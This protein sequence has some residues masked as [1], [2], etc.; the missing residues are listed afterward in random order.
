[1]T[2]AIEVITSVQRR[3]RW[4]KPEKE[5]ICCGG[6]GAGR[7]RVRNSSRGWDPHEPIVPVAPQLCERAQESVVFNPVAIVT[8]NGTFVANAAATPEPGFIEIEFA[9]S[10]RIRITGLVD[11]RSRAARGSGWRQATPTCARALMAW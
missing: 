3:R 5:Q 4:S 9:T 8:E 7:Q 6:D 11:A 1:M 2:K 10:G